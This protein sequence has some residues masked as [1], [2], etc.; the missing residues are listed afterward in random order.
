MGDTQI[1]Q[2]NNPNEVVVGGMTRG[3]V[4]TLKQTLT[5]QGINDA[6][7]N[8][9][10]QTCAAS[11][12]NPFMNHIYAIPYKSKMNIQISVDGIHF[13][14]RKH[15]DYI[16]ASAEIVGE[17]EVENFEAEL[18][19]GQFKILKHKISL[20][21]RGK[22]VAAYAIAKR[23][24]APDQV[25]FMDRSEV[26]HM[27][28]GIN[29]L[30]KSNFNDMFKKHV[31]KRALKSQFGVDI[32]DQTVEGSADSVQSNARSN[33]R[34][35]IVIDEN[36]TTTEEEAKESLLKEI[37]EELDKYNLSPQEIRELSIKHFKTEEENLNLQQL[38]AL[39][40]FI[41]FEA[42]NKTEVIDQQPIVVD[43][44]EGT[45][46]AQFGFDEIDFEDIEVPFNE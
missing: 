11:G 1:V 28:K 20:P 8:L 3:E 7:F 30:W 21:F 19:D 13:L 41:G 33:E 6:Q 5:P 24:D 12:L 40:K 2:K 9:F 38:S 45:S 4:A 16:T 25:I 44:G 32:D 31:L 14:A 39:K 18:V 36:V 23:K 15:P 26:E 42:N 46:E 27:E 29:P 17:N 10:I 37:R 22:A 34:R 35:E 43:P